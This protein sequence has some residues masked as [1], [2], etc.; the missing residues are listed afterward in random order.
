MQQ[1]LFVISFHFTQDQ[2]VSRIADGRPHT[3]KVCRWEQIRFVL[4]AS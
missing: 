1:Q 3:R 4:R 2:I